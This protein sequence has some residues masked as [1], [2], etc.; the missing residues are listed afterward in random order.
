MTSWDS[1]LYLRFGEERTRPSVD[2]VA[3]I[4]VPGPA[5][6]VDLGCG[7]GNSTQVLRSRWPQA[8]VIGLD[9]SPDMIAA[10]RRDH[11]DQEWILASAELWVAEKP[12]DIIFSNAAIQ[13]MRDHE[14]LVQHWF[15][16]LAPGGALAFQLPSNEYSPVRRLIDEIAEDPAWRAR[17]GAAKSALT[18]E[19]PPLYY[20]ALA[21][22]ARSL[23]IWETEYDHVM[24]HPQ[25]I[26]EWISSTGL[27]PF[28]AALDT[29]REQERFLGML[30]EAVTQA[31]P[32]RV[33]GKV[34]FPFRRLFVIAYR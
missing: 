16:Q 26:V 6:I 34:L 7:P 30:N 32:R 29:E 22:R 8:S 5:S 10:A 25:A 14:A 11:P 3:R 17:M 19:A 18:M 13:W 4:A 1:S 21:T 12:V 23:D 2:L 15:D 31:Y 9:S 33:D 28:L 20:D 27:R 24:D